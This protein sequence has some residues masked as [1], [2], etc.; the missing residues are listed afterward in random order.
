MMKKNVI[1]QV[2]RKTIP[3]NLNLSCKFQF[4]ILKRGWLIIVEG[5]K[6]HINISH[7]IV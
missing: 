1:K 2:L 7:E 6:F 3:K 5:Q 4:L